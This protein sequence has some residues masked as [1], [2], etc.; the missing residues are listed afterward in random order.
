MRGPAVYDQPTFEV[1]VTPEGG[2]E[3]RRTQS[4]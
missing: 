2:L 3:A 1:R 4:A